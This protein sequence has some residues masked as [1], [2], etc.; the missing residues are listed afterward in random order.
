MTSLLCDNARLRRA[1][2]IARRELAAA[3]GIAQDAPLLPGTLCTWRNDE[4]NRHLLAP[5]VVIAQHGDAV[6][7]ALRGQDGIVQRQIARGLLRE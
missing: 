1:N 2:Q 6:E 7:C 4:W 3:Y 5:I